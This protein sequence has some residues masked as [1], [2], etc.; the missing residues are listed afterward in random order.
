MHSPFSSNAMIS[1]DNNA[2]TLRVTKPEIA[3]VINKRK[4]R[5]NHKL[6]AQ[7]VSTSYGA[8][9]QEQKRRVGRKYRKEDRGG[10]HDA[11]LA[12]LAGAVNRC[13]A[14]FPFHERH[15]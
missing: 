10:K 15:P 13:I 8:I 14:P 2:E 7:A 3:D 1:S 6:S 9:S 11:L 12:I 5:S 4:P